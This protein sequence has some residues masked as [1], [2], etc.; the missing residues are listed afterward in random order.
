MPRLK[1]IK[2]WSTYK[3]GDIMETNSPATVLWLVNRYGF[4]V[5]EEVPKVEI[6]QIEAAPKNKMISKPR[7]MKTYGRS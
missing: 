4:A 7:A 5:I 1:F 3:P 6:K 2:A